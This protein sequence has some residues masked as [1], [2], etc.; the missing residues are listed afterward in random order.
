MACSARTPLS[1]FVELS[2]NG[3][4]HHE[5]ARLTPGIR[6][7]PLKLLRYRT[8][9]HCTKSRTSRRRQL[10]CQRKNILKRAVSEA[11]DTITADAK[12]RSQTTDCVVV[13]SGI[14]GEGVALL[15]RSQAHEVHRELEVRNSWLYE[16]D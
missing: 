11:T 8:A 3:A 2:A 9:G 13:G 15:S 6:T 10:D 16:T 5:R 14:G 4:H 1:P 12:D 7:V